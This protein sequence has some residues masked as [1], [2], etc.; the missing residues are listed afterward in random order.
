MISMMILKESLASS[1]DLPQ[2]KLSL[3]LHRGRSVGSNLLRHA[4]VSILVE[5]N[6]LWT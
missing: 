5:S 4:C 3:Q 2:P 6:K 1:V